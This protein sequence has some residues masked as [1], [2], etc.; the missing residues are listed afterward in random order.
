M[1]MN[2]LINITPFLVKKANKVLRFK[3][4]FKNSSTMS[5]Y[6]I[7]NGSVS[8]RRERLYCFK[9]IRAVFTSP[10]LY[11]HNNQVEKLL[12]YSCLLFQFYCSDKHIHAWFGFFSVTFR[13]LKKKFLSKNKYFPS[14]I[15]TI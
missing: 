1:L 2:F 4:R 10:E 11:Q 15:S 5:E 9:S 6:K 12:S 3:N 7:G 13:R 8:H 14:K